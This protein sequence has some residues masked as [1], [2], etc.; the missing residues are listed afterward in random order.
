M[1]M[2]HVNLKALVRIITII[3]AILTVLTLIAS[4]ISGWLIFKWIRYLDAARKA[5]P[6]MEK[7]ADLYMEDRANKTKQ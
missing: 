5:M 4:A 7:A 3:G 1:K 2:D 6:K